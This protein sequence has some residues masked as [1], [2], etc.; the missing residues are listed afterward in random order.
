MKSF[1]D[2]WLLA[3]KQSGVFSVIDGLSSECWIWGGSFRPNGYGRYCGKSAHRTAWIASNGEIP[4]G[5]LVCHKCDNTACVRPEHLFLGTHKDNS[6][7]ASR[8][9]RTASGDSN[10]SRKHRERMKRGDSHYRRIDPSLGA[11]DEKHGRAKMTIQSVSELRSLHNEGVSELK[12]AIRF[13]IGKS[14]A[15]RIVS[16]QHWK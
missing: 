12:L 4:A 7:D 8:K 3:N 5:M 11:R 2:F 1:L 10:G 16:G 9:G 6:V 13:G 14:Q 15:H